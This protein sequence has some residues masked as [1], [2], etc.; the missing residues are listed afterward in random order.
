MEMRS[1]LSRARGAGGSKDGAAHHWWSERIWAIALIPLLIWFAVSAVSLVGA[2][3]AAF[4]EWAGAHGNP[5]LLI[6]FTIAMYHHGQMGLTVII[7]DYV[8]GEA[9]NFIAV[10]LTKLVAFFCAAYTI[11]SVIRLTFGT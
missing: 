10:L 1:P 3:H 8:H 11:F 9:V 6:L 5:V 2:D 7:E 4:K